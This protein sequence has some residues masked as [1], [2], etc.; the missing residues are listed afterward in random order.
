MNNCTNEA[1]KTLSAHICQQNVEKNFKF[2]SQANY[3]MLQNCIVHGAL[4][5]ICQ[6]SS[7]FMERYTH[8]FLI[9]WWRQLWMIKLQWT[10][11]NMAPKSVTYKNAVFRLFRLPCSVELIL[12]IVLPF[13]C[14]F[15]ALVWGQKSNS[16]SKPGNMMC[17]VLFNLILCLSEPLCW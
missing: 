11:M 3:I 17:F 6:F 12:P 9:V 2:G 15:P 7:K 16:K 1:G 4:K 13:G 5:Q 8:S 10:S 14:Y